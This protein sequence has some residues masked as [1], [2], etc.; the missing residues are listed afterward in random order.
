MIVDLFAGPGGWD[1]GA[2]ML[3][4]RTV[5]FELDAAACATGK[6]AGHERVRCDVAT[7]PLEHM[8][9]VEGLIAS[10]PCQDF[11]VAGKGAGRTGERG[12]LIDVVPRWV[13]TLR[14]EWV[15]CEQVPPCEGIW[16]E[17]A[18]LY[19]ELGY[20]TWVGVL[21]AADFGVPQTRR[22]AFLLAS[23]VRPV[24]PPE[25][26]HARN[27][28][29]SLFGNQLA[30]WVTMA[31]ALGWG[32]GEVVTTR[33]DRKPSGGNEFGADRPS[34]ALTEKA[35]SWVV[36]TGRDW[37]LGGD[38][39]DAQTFDASVEP[40]RTI[41]GKGRWHL[42]DRGRNG[43]S[44][45]LDMPAQTIIASHDNG[46][47]RWVERRN[48]QSGPCP[49]PRWPEWRPAT[50]VAGRD[51][52]PDPGSNAN[53]FNGASK[54]RNDGYRIEL[55]E[56][57]VLQSF[58]RDYPWQGSRTKQFEQVGNAVPPRLA[59]HVLSAVTGRAHIE[60]SAA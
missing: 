56:A 33:G 11:S 18:A 8:R 9:D 29:P 59:A 41:D 12:Q 10:P 58:P 46:D 30:P 1:E 5:G 28:E 3:G 13:K 14:P 53:R 20:S 44:R 31:E 39:C 38:R 7:W 26:T 17:H 42:E 19:R 35:R 21:N 4:L 22:R 36:N 27:P 50:T 37:K 52:V 2:A 60:A 45:P 43:A 24:A 49:N 54:S 34:W 51:L 23:R 57:A 16:R 48:D 47:L 6:V 32:T 40:A 55:A 15:A 25:P